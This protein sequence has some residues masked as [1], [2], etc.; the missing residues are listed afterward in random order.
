M[1]LAI[2]EPPR[3]VKA[4]QVEKLDSVRARDLDGAHVP[5]VK[6]SRAFAD[7]LMLLANTAVP[8]RHLPPGK[9][10]HLGPQSQV[11]LVQRGAPHSCALRLAGRWGPFKSALGHRHIGTRQPGLAYKVGLLQIKQ[12]RQSMQVQLGVPRIGY[13][14]GRAP[15]LVRTLQV[16]VGP[17]T[18]QPDPLTQGMASSGGLDRFRPKASQSAPHCLHICNRPHDRVLGITIGAAFAGNPQRPLPKGHSL[19]AAL[20]LRQG[21]H[22]VF[23]RTQGTPQRGLSLVPENRNG[24][25]ALLVVRRIA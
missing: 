14:T 25:Y 23:A 4:D 5:H 15:D 22:P 19:Q 12:V 13:R 3:I 6:E 17:R 16:Y 11:L 2:L 8:N 20:V 21:G 7:R 1:R 18:R 24:H 10:D 9:F